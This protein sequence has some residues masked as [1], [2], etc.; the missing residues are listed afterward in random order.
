[1]SSVLVLHISGM[2]ITCVKVIDDNDTNFRPQWFIKSGYGECL[3]D[4]LQCNIIKTYNV[5]LPW[6]KSCPSGLICMLATPQSAYVT[7]TEQ[8]IDGGWRL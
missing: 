8:I 6:V 2:H 7:G 3:T 5:N 1:M 4:S